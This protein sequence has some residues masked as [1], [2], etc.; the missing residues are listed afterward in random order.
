MH[1]AVD[2]DGTIVEH[3]YPKIGS[4]IP[5]AIDNLKAMVAEGHK[6]IL[7][8]VREEDL[9]V[10][11]VQFCSMRGLDFYAVNADDPDVMW[12]PHKQSR[13]LCNVDLYIDDRQ[14]GGLPDWD[15]IHRYVNKLS[16]RNLK[17]EAKEHKKR[18][19]KHL[20]KHHQSIFARIAARSREARA[21]LSH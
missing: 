5:G 1:I 6:L 10:E 15:E 17:A 19:K 16:N 18:K 2:F 11:A 14:V 9:L 12:D 3:K 8:T 13:K 21:N 7:W 4:E 20:K